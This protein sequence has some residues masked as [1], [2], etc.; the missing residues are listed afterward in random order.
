MLTLINRHIVVLIFII[1]ALGNLNS[2][3]I[4]F[5]KVKDLIIFEASINQGPKGK[6]ILDTGAEDLFINNNSVPTP[7]NDITSF[8]TLNGSIDATT[9]NTLALNIGNHSL[10]ID[11]AYQLDLKALEDF[12]EFPLL[13]LIGYKCLLENKMIIDFEQEEIIFNSERYTVVDEVFDLSLWNGL[14][15][16][17]IKQNGESLKLLLDTGVSSHLINQ[18]ALDRLSLDHQVL[19]TVSLIDHVGNSKEINRIHIGSFDQLFNG[20]A[21]FLVD[22]L[23]SRVGEGIDGIIN[24]SLLNIDYIVFD[25]KKGTCAVKSHHAVASSHP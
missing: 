16:V 4:P 12:V 24:P 3:S 11:E 7:S 2:K 6:F 14:P 21:F 9:L 8:Q 23:E 13:G 10:N 20:D 22:D 5:E 19:S 1:G 25:F 15:Y 18:Y 17:T